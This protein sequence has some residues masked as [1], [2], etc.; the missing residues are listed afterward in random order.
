[1]EKQTLKVY[2]A[3]PLFSEME[4]SYNAQVVERIRREFKDGEIEIYLPQENMKINDKKAYASSEMI[5]KADTD[6]LVSSDVLI[7]VLDGQTI[8]AG[9]AS[10]IGIAY[11]EGMA[12]IGISTDSRS[13]GYDNEKKIKALSKVGENQFVY[14][15]L[16]TTGLINLSGTIVNSTEDLIKELGKF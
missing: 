1:M 8:D 13:Q 3:S 9:V 5:A 2:F 12:I 10:E 15:N 6:E 16:Y 4:K 14:L 7:A 11:G